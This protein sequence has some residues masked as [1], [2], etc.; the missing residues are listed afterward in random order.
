MVTPPSAIKTARLTLRALDLSDAA[1]LLPLF[2]DEDSLRYWAHGPVADLAELEAK[3]RW[4][5][6]PPET[7][8]TYAMAERADGP[9]LGWVNLYAIQHRMA[10]AGYILAPEKRGLGYAREALR[11]L[12]QLGFG[13]LDLHRIY[14]DIDPENSAS[15]RLAQDL[16]FRWEG[17][18]RQSFFRDGQYF[19]SVFYAMLRSDWLQMETPL[20]ETAPPPKGTEIAGT[21]PAKAD[22]DER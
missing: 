22:G 19:D 18:F 16:R 10:G 2:R 14:L 13:A 9:A 7:V 12:L 6:G 15:I 5:I 17:H 8:V 11:A 20:N 1:A 21:Q 4:N 3:L